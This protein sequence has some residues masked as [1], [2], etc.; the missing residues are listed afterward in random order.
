MN[1]V[2]IRT[3]PTKIKRFRWR[4]AINYWDNLLCLRVLSLQVYTQRLYFLGYV[5]GLRVL[6][7][8]SGCVL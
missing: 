8:G 3:Y 2:N 6:E 4:D 7:S 1:V 5:S